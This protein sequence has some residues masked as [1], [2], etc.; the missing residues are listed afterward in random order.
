MDIGRMLDLTALKVLHGTAVGPMFGAT[1][2][3]QK[4]DIRSAVTLP[5]V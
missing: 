2:R 1:S 3:M 5:F 4:P